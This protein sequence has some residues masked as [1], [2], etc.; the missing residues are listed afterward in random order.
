MA[1]LNL[2]LASVLSI[3]PISV[4]CFFTTLF[5]YLKVDS[6]GLA[7]ICSSIVSGMFL[8]LLLILSL[9]VEV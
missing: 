7:V 9:D 6:V 8:N 1:V 5:V 4:F 2:L 3:L